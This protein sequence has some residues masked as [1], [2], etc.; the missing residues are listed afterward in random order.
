MNK[1]II[2]TMIINLIGVIVF[3]LEGKICAACAHIQCM[4]WLDIIRRDNNFI[5]YLW[6]ALRRQ[7]EINER[8]D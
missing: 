2:L 6:K 1:L 5:D 3:A 8:K 4:L 7:R